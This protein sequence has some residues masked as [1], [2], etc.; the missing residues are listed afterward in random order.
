[1]S[2]FQN[3]L[4]R[5]INNTN[6]VQSVVTPLPTAN[7]DAALDGI[8]SFVNGALSAI[9]MSSYIFVDENPIS[10][11]GKKDT[12]MLMLHPGYYYFDSATTDN[13][14]GET[15]VYQLPLESSVK[16]AELTSNDEAVLGVFLTLSA[17]NQTNGEVLIT[18]TF[19]GVAATRQIL[20]DFQKPVN[21]F[22]PCRTHKVQEDKTYSKSGTGAVGDPYIVDTAVTID[23]VSTQALFKATSLNPAGAD[24]ANIA[25][26][27]QNV[28]IEVETISN[29]FSYLKAYFA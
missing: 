25:L 21:V 7:F 6:N 3:F 23:N 27:Y 2:K 5:V 10:V 8:G 17:T 29:L 11:S 13:V 1:M 18:S 14:F 16:Y 9:Q 15:E 22:I 19:D 28:Y 12:E 24:P 4:T 26:K 20:I